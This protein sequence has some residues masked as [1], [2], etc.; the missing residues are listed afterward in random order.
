MQVQRAIAA[1]ATGPNRRPS[2]RREAV[3]FYEPTSPHRMCRVLPP[4]F[5]RVLRPG[6]HVV[7]R[8]T[9][10]RKPSSWPTTRRSD[11]PQASGQRAAKSGEFI[12]GIEALGQVF[13]NASVASDPRLHFGGMKRS[14]YGREL[15]TA[16][17]REFVNTKT[18]WIR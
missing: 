12:D 9:T 5:A 4:S 11:S 18:V 1:G 15:G 10:P 6:R 3:N 2:N 17:I 7:S 16:G 13:V 14:G 8:R